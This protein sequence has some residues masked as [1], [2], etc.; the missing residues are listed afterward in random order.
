MKSTA[1]ATLMSFASAMKV[2]GLHLLSELPRKM[3]R[4]DSSQTLP[5]KQMDHLPTIPNAIH[6]QT[7]QML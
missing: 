5:T 4:Y 3:V 7:V 2:N 6:S 1:F